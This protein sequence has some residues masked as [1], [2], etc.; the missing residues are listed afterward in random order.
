MKYGGFH[1]TFDEKIKGIVPIFD[2]IHQSSNIDIF[3]IQVNLI[4]N[5][6]GHKAHELSY[7]L[8]VVAEYANK[9]SFLGIKPGQLLSALRIK[10]SVGND[11]FLEI[12]KLRALRLL[13]KNLCDAYKVD[14]TKIKLKIDVETSWRFMSKLDPHTNLL[15]STSS[16][17]SAI[18]GGCD[19]LDVLP[20]DLAQGKPDEFSKR[21]ARNIQII[22][23]EEANLDKVIDPSSGSGYLDQI[24]FELA[25]KGW[26]TFQEIEKGGGILPLIRSGKFQNEIEKNALKQVSDFL[27]NSR[28][29]V[30]TNI[31]PNPS[32]KAIKKEVQK[33]IFTNLVGG[34]KEEIIPL[35][36]RRVLE[37]IENKFV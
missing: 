20:F 26:Q 27:S 3:T 5:S 36:Q 8:S 25:E 30:G 17:F 7:F 31:Y 2:Q 14:F 10:I 16:A 13:W 9:L 21:Q 28:K 11:Q 34:A 18:I 1:D 24:T 33:I 4:H 6:G 15:R 19:S 29:A 12:A 37:E 32:E 35:V 22:L 23:A